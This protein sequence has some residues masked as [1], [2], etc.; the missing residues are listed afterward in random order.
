MTES[1][2]RYKEKSSFYPEAILVDK[3][4]R[5]KEKRDYCKYRG[6]HLSGP[7]LGRS[8]ED[9]KKEAKKQAYQVFYDIESGLRRSGRKNL[10]KLLRKAA[11]GKFDYIITKSISR[12]S[13]DTLEF[14]KIIKFLRERGI[15]MHFESEKLVS[16]EA[17]K[18]FEIT[19]RGMLAQDESRNTS[20]N[21][22]WGIQRKFE[23]G[24][25]Y[26]KYKNFMGF[27]CVNGEIGNCAGT[28]I[29]SQKDI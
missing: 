27:T 3:I 2:E 22:K 20:E 16:I 5:T 14:L 19:L 6:I 12:V 10:D 29:S 25:I 26:T 24:E 1:L 23:K 17:N 15:N 28:G 11:K 7:E 4:C 13:R 8:S 18:E 21:I 9:E